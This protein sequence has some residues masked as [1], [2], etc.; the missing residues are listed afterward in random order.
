MC[1]PHHSPKTQLFNLC[2]GSTTV[3][4]VHS[5]LWLRFPVQ[6]GHGD[7]LA[8]ILSDSDPHFATELT[9]FLFSTF[10]LTLPA[11]GGGAWLGRHYH[12]CINC[13]TIAVKGGI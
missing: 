2:A 5:R 3:F 10:L 13:R 6:S 8:A 9:G 4:S 11:L 12:P 7:Y 1:S